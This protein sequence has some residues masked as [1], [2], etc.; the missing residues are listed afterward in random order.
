MQKDSQSGME[1]TQR[2]TAWWHGN[3]YEIEAPAS[4]EHNRGA[5]GKEPLAHLTHLQ[6]VEFIWPQ[7]FSSPGDADSI[8]DLVKP[9]RLSSETPLLD[10]GAGFGGA[11][12]AMAHAFGVYVTGLEADR[13]FVERGNM[14]TVAAGLAKHVSLKLFDPEFF[15]L[16]E[17]K[18]DRVFSKEFIFNIRNKTRAFS[19]IFNTLRPRGEFLFTDYVIGPATDAS[20]KLAEQFFS[21]ET[22][23]IQL[24]SADQTVEEL[25]LTGFD[26]RIAA[27]VTS[28]IVRLIL[29]NFQRISGK[30]AK[31]SQIGQLDPDSLALLNREVGVWSRRVELLQSNALKVFRFHAIR[32]NSSTLLSNW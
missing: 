25:K 4:E 19:T 15:D 27:D 30:L 1:F 18:Y 24:K 10:I 12:R 21:A 23:K 14:E 26:V 28:T 16:P 22:S 3:E 29:S 20:N 32:P 17:R 13:E 11:D 8:I 9:L 7:G 31:S 6:A 2:L 5:S